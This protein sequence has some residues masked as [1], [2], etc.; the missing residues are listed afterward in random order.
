[1]K[2]NIS[3][4]VLNRTKYGRLLNY[5]QE[6]KIITRSQKAEKEPLFVIHSIGEI[7]VPAPLHGDKEYV[8]KRIILETADIKEKIGD[9]LAKLRQGTRGLV[10]L[11]KESHF[12]FTISEANHKTFTDIEKYLERE[13]CFVSGRAYSPLLY[14]ARAGARGNPVIYRDIVVCTGSP[15][16]LEQ[17]NTMVGLT[18]GFIDLAFNDDVLTGL[19]TEPITI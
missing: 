4:S 8:H 1:M 7:G 19:N 2:L 5:I 17:Q 3:I 10:D 16:N 13:E 9:N 14:L 6:E 15:E 11:L 12:S 18:H